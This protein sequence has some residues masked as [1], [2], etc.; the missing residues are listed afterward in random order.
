MEHRLVRRFDIGA[1]L[2]AE[3]Y[4][5]HLVGQDIGRQ[6]RE[7][8]EEQ[9]RTT[10]AGAVTTLDCATVDHLDFSA[11]DECVAK[12]VVRVMA[13]EY[14]D[15]FLVLAGLTPTQEANVFVALE[16]KKLATLIQRQTG[17]EIIG[18]LNPYLRQ[19]FDFLAGIKV[20]TARDWAE[21]T[22]DAITLG[23][24]KLQNLYKARLA[25]RRSERLPDGGRQF[26]Y[27]LVEGSGGGMR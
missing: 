6:V 18:H 8:I 7:A 24:T 27:S 17:T 20:G 22:G 23:S 12:L 5:T 3:A 4:T 14:G 13:L 2:Q 21:A 15:I 26:I 1:W 19:G 11:A 16:R 25:H 10:D 9:L